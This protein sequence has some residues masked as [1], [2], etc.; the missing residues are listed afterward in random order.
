MNK[1][2]LLSMVVTLA[3]AG[4]SV[5]SNVLDNKNQEETIAKKAAEAVSK[6]LEEANK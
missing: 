1:V 2:K 6:A 3:G 4:L 5:A